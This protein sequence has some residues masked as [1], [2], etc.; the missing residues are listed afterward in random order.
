M[1]EQID[2]RLLDAASALHT[3]FDLDKVTREFHKAICSLISAD[4]VAACL[5][6]PEDPFYDWY[7][8]DCPAAF[9]EEY[10]ELA[11]QDFIAA[12]VRQ[13]PNQV[14]IDREMAPRSMIESN[15]LYVRAHELGLPFQQAMSVLVTTEF[16]H[17][18][19]TFY[20]TRCRPFAEPERRALQALVK[21]LGQAISRCRGYVHA[22]ELRELVEACLFAEGAMTFIVDESGCEQFRSGGLTDFLGKWFGNADRAPNGLPKL[23]P[24]WR[25]IVLRWP[26]G[27]DMGL[28]FAQEQKKLRL[29]IRGQRIRSSRGRQYVAFLFVQHALPGL[30]EALACKLTPRQ[31]EVAQAALQ[32]WDNQLIA[33]ELGCAHETVKKHIYWI[34]QRLGVENR[35]HLQLLAQKLRGDG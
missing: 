35:M 13:C 12:A 19:I 4:V 34:F 10:P 9:F 6:R 16:G 25:D 7:T 26:P 15:R 1:N 20:R 22:V 24:R 32:G 14:L 30:P 3:S 27:Q 21:H 29:E 18:G 5:S 28:L 31:Q 2:R 33:Q 11:P 23:L 17:G 8:T